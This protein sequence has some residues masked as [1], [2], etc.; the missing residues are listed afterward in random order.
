M[1]EL[2]FVFHFDFLLR[3][4]TFTS[5]HFIGEGALLKF[6]KVTHG[7]VNNSKNKE[8]FEGKMLDLNNIE[9][10]FRT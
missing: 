2:L 10:N 5:D 8:K 3:F 6:M 9:M 1:F 7:D 4:F